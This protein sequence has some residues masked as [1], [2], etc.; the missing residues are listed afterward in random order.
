MYT[1][2]F[3]KLAVVGMLFYMYIHVHVCEIFIY[4]SKPL[5]LLYSLIVYECVDFLSSLL[6][7]LFATS[8]FLSIS[9]NGALCT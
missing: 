4:F 5:R 7:L 6:N 3:S 2:C 8:F 9:K 1:M